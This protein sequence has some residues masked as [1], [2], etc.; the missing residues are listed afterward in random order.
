MD[1]EAIAEWDRIHGTTSGSSINFSPEVE[2]YAQKAEKIAALFGVQKEYIPIIRPLIYQESIGKL[3]AVSPKGAQ[4]LMQVMPA[5]GA[6]QFQKLG[7]GQYDPKNPNDNIVAGVSYLGDQLQKYN[8]PA[9]AL[10]AYNA[11]PGAVDKYGGIPPYKET[12]NYVQNIMAKFN[13]QAPAQPA[14]EPQAIDMAD[15]PPEAV[16][17]WNASQGVDTQ[18]VQQPEESDYLAGLAG[19]VGQGASFGLL[20]EAMGKAAK[21]LGK[22]YAKYV[23]GYPEE[24]VNKADP[25]ELEQAALDITRGDVKTF[26]KENPKTALAAELAGGL[27][28]PMGGVAKF[29]GAGGNALARTARA[30]LA[31]GGLGAAYGFG[32]GEGSTNRI[33]KAFLGGLGGAIGGTAAQ[34][35]IEL[36]GKVLS[37]GPVQRTATAAYNKLLEESGAINPVSKKPS[38]QLKLLAKTL[39]GSTADDLEE[40]IAQKAIADQKGIPALISDVMNDPALTG[41]AK[42]YGNIRPGQKIAEESLTKMQ[43]EQADRVANIISDLAPNDKS[44]YDAGEALSNA[45]G[46]LQKGYRAEANKAAEPLFEE[47]HAKFPILESEKLNKILNKKIPQD[48]IKQVRDADI[49]GTL[50]GVPDN[51]SRL[52]QKVLASAGEEIKNLEKAKRKGPLQQGQSD[53]LF[54]LK[55]MKDAIEK[56]L[57][58]LN[59][60][61]LKARAKYPE[62]MKKLNTLKGSQADVVRLLDKGNYQKAGDLIFKKLEPKQIEELKNIGGEVLDEDLKTLG[63]S[64]LQDLVLGK[65]EGSDV[66]R[67]LLNTPKSKQRFRALFE[68]EVM[69]RLEMFLKVEKKIRENQ[70]KLRFRSDTATNLDLER[71]YGSDGVLGK[72]LKW[73]TSTRAALGDIGEALAKETPKEEFARS[74]AEILYDPNKTSSTLEALRPLL[75]QRDAYRA[76]VAKGAEKI[77]TGT[78]RLNTLISTEKD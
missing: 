69:D 9:L 27:A 53:T 43:G 29:V 66:L 72:L 31:G 40:A 11:G 68:P 67:G 57:E 19:T 49:L 35:L 41:A 63:R 30:G 36:G 26:R 37:S 33:E 21:Y 77:G 55:Q 13:D 50:E 54:G 42:Y 22:P 15:V 71:Q 47:A 76:A 58:T 56:E 52:V 18:P 10:A 14:P 17:M 1:A 61:L 12:Q 24:I 59:P 46:K 5:T 3:N 70:N 34:P 25:A 62:I 6:A 16:D 64:Y 60:D 20:D 73:S 39:S 23:L 2:P 7:L 51:S 38:D 65:P 45:I 8:D 28:V 32:Q 74:M 75:Q 78:R 44:I 4:G 48:I